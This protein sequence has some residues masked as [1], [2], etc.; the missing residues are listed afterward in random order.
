M[1][2]G[3]ER[4]LTPELLAT[5]GP[6][7]LARVRARRRFTVAVAEGTMSGWPVAVALAADWVIFSAN[8]ELVIDCGEAWSGVLSRIGAA[9]LRLHLLESQPV[10]ASIAMQYGLCDRVVAAEEDPVECAQRWLEGRSSVAL[11]A[12]AALI[13]RRGGDPLERAEFARLFAA[14]EPQAGLK[15]FLDKKRHDW[16]IRT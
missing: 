3:I 8:T 14:G 12:S 10:K 16:K 11:E 15:A 4:L 7:L 13:T 2:A 9:A 6:Q 1:T 5:A